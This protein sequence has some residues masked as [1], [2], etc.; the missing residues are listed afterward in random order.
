MEQQHMAG[1]GAR[2]IW[3]LH[4]AGMFRS[5]SKLQAAHLWSPSAVAMSQSGYILVTQ[6]LNGAQKLRT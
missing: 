4:F 3:R 5:N 2:R 6:L 1:Q